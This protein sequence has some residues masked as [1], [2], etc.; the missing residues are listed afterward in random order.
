[1]GDA[2]KIEAVRTM[3]ALARVTAKPGLCSAAY[4]DVGVHLQRLRHD[5][6]KVDFVDLVQ[7]CCG[8]SA[9][10]AY[11]LMAVASG[12]K[13]LAEVRRASAARRRKHFARH[14]K[15]LE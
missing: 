3:L 12:A 7:T 8:L 9:S 14:S 4:R 5:R 2:D 6:R 11:E 15:G 10:R 1:M 13:S